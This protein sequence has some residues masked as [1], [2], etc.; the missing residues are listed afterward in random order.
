MTAVSYLLAR[1]GRL[2]IEPV[3]SGHAGT[4]DEGFLS[5]IMP[6]SLPAR[7]RLSLTLHDLDHEHDIDSENAYVKRPAPRN[8]QADRPISPIR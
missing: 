7:R 1:G 5:I 2:G 4:K 6:A 3:I 8:A